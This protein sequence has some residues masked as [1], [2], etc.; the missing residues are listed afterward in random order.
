MPEMR[1]HPVLLKTIPSG[2]FGRTLTQQEG[3][4]L[5]KLGFCCTRNCVVKQH[6]GMEHKGVIYSRKQK[7]KR[8]MPYFNREIYVGMKPAYECPKNK[9][10]HVHEE[11]IER[12][13]AGENTIG[14]AKAFNVSTPTVCGLLELH[15]VK[16][17]SLHEA[18]VL[19]M[20]DERRE[21]LRQLRLGK[22]GPTLGRIMPHR[23]GE[24]GPGWKGGVYPLVQLIRGDITYD[25]WRAEVFVRDN[26]RC[27]ICDKGGAGLNAHHIAYF[28]HIIEWYEIKT[29]EQ[30]LATAI[31]W[32]V[33]NG[34]TLCRECHKFV[35][36]MDSQPI[37]IPT[38]SIVTNDGMWL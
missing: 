18:G 34:R 3:N 14:L 6:N 23:R 36:F 27:Q 37:P 11:V 17:R 30:A 32:D 7:M 1:F 31:L 13:L 15:G 9:L 5:R 10:E 12:Y 4:H 38:V 22:P 16:R 20:T 25:K 19:A 8:P 35:H 21:A 29:L 24:N 26:Y 2:E 33:D 28:S